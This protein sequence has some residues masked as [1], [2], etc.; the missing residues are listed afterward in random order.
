MITGGSR[1]I[2][3]AVVLRLAADGYDVAFCY[4]AQAEAAEEVTKCVGPTGARVLVRQ[5]DVR[6]EARVRAF[7]GAAEEELGP[8]DVLVSCAG[9]V[10]DAPLVH[11]TAED[12]E[13]VLAVNLDGTYRVCRAAI[14]SFMRRRTGCLITVSSVAGVYG[15]AGQVNYAAAKAGIIGFTRSL[16]KEVARLGIRVNAVAPG[17]VETDMTAGLTERQRQDALREIPMGR[18]GRADE[19]ADAVAFLASERA[20]Y[21]SGQVL[22]VD[23][24]LTL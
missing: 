2:G 15:H 7:V 4:R 20:A 21:V 24:G 16:A 19:I 10:R 14:F 8:L 9:I 6:D 23:G 3:R 18:L 13:D 12:W 11:M 22:Q 1:G 17:F 5:V